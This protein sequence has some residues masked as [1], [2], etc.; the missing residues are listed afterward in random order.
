MVNH[1]AEN[2]LLTN[3]QHGF[4]SG[5]SC[6]T[7]LLSVIEA[8]TDQLEKGMDIDALYFDFSKA[9]DT[10]PHRRL[11]SKLQSY[12]IS[13]QIIDWVEAYLSN[14]KQRVL[15]NGTTSEWEPVSSGVPRGSVLGPVLFLVYIN[16]LPK[17]VKNSIRLFADDTKIYRT[18]TT[19]SDCLSLQKDI[20]SIEEWASKWQLKFHPKKCKTM[21]I[22]V[23]HPKYNYTMTAEDGTIVQ[24]EETVMEKDLGVVVDNKLTFSQHIN[25]TVV[26]ANQV[27]GMIRRS[28]KYMD[29]EIFVQLF[30]SRV[31]PILEYG[32]VI[33]NPRLIR[34]IDAIE[35]VQRRATQ[36]VPGISTMSYPDRLRTLRLPSLVYRR[37]R[38]DMIETYKFLHNGV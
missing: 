8:W 36:T 2:N 11:L 16:D 1:M 22:G 24:L 28:F 3:D 31:R 10:V 25:S 17:S 13:K 5:R 12:K 32:N 6:T 38:G 21:R 20:D 33:W 23:K 27:V 18:V 34:D 37:A 7:Q 4:W 29:K 26:K 30:T 15:V 35:R 19:D 9:F 14:R